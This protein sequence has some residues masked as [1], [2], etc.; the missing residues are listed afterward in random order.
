[1]LKRP[2]IIKLWLKM[3]LPIL[4]EPVLSKSIAAIIG[5]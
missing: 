4:V 3:N 5:P 2:G 1:M